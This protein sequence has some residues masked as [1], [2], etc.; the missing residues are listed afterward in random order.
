MVTKAKIKKEGSGKKTSPLGFKVLNTQGKEVEK[1]ELDPEVFD[2]KVKPALIQQAVVAYRANQRKGLASTKNRGKVSGGGKKPWRQKGTGRARV[3]SSRSPLWRGGGVI[4]GPQPHSY[5]KD[6][7]KKMRIQALKSALN[8][9]WKDREMIILDNLALNSH[10]TQDFYK[11][12]GNLQVEGI[13]TRFVV[14]KFTDNLKLSS[15]NIKKVSLARASDIH[16]SEAIDCRR[17]VL[18]KKALREVEGRIKGLKPDGDK[19]DKS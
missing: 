12:V 18:T 3:G 16:A 14:E 2:G 10:K 5:R 15:G 7:P 6:L 9:K 19:S 1:I 17:L 11:I 4:F 8:A 13:N